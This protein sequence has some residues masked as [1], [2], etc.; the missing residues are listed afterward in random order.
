MLREYTIIKQ[1]GKEIFKQQKLF[2]YPEL[3]NLIRTQK[4]N[5]KIE[6]E[7]TTFHGKRMYVKEILFFNNGISTG[8]VFPC[9]TIQRNKK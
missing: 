2:P 6:V 5:G 3:K 4:I 7:L 1:E 8:A 9:L